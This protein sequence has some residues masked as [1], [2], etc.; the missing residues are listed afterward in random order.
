VHDLIVVGG[1]PVGASLARA[2]RGLSVALVAQQPPAPAAGLDARVY[3]LSPGN[4]AF[5]RELGAWQALPQD[6]LA[7]VHTMRVHGEGSSLEFDAY[8]AGAPGLSR[9]PCC[10]TRFGAD[11]NRAS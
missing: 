4:V 1:G 3:A 11:S 5:L 10:R 7:A 8:E 2:V 9:T 6:R